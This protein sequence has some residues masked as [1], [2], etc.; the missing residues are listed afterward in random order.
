M[1][2]G[3]SGASSSSAVYSSCISASVGTWVQ[4]S[5]RQS[6]CMLGHAAAGATKMLV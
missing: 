4:H 1:C 2:G 5:R 6:V 3:S